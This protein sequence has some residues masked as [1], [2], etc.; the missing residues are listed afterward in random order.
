MAQT[1]VVR[2]VK[3]E[4]VT[5]AGYTEIIY[6]GTTVVQF[7]DDKIILNSNGWQTVTTKARM[8]QTSNQYDLGFKVY[9]K[10]HCWYVDY[11]GTTVD[12]RDNMVITRLGSHRAIIQLKDGSNYIC[13]GKPTSQSKWFDTINQAVEW[14]SSLTGLDSLNELVEIESV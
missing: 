2:G 5:R 1:Q 7:N 13:T 6:R 14:A 12:Y 9:Q 3:T 4:I 11:R 10:K 8:T